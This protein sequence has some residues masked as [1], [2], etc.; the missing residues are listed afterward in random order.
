MRKT[1]AAEAHLD[2]TI[3]NVRDKAKDVAEA[4]KTRIDAVKE[5]KE[6]FAINIA[7]DIE[8]AAD[9]VEEEMAEE[10][11]SAVKIVDITDKT[12]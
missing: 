11:D 6:D 2:E 4:A 1:K 10:L 3:E 5:S 12:E 7:E 9:A 8:E